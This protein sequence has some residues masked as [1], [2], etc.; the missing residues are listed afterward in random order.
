MDGGKKVWVP[1]TADGFKLGRITDIG[2]DNISIEPFDAPGTTIHSV[3]DRV[4]PAEEY[5]NK[6]VADN[7]GLMYLNEATLLHNLRIRYMKNMIYTYTANILIALNPYYEVPDLYTNATIQK[8]QGKSLGTMPPHVYAIADKALRDMKVTK[9]SQSIIVSG[10]SGAGKTESTKYI[11]KYLTMSRGQSSG[12]IEQRILESNPLL[13]A[14]GNAKTMRNN[15]SSRFG[16]F[17][18]IH[19]S[20]KMMLAGGFISHYLL[21]KSRICVQSS[22]ERNYHIFYRLCAGAPDDLYQKLKLAPP[23]HFRYLNRGCTQYFCG[24]QSDKAMSQG[25]KSKQY[26][27]DGSLSDPVIDDVQNFKI[28]DDA[29]KH[30]G[31]SDVDRLSVYKLVAGVLH[32]GNIGFEENHEDT[33]GGCKVVGGSEVALGAAAEL[34]ALDKEELREALMSRIMQAA[35]GGSK[36]TIIKVPLK[37]GEASNARDALAKSIYSRLFD[38]IVSSI[39]KSIPFSSSVSFIGLL[40][41]AGFEYFQVNSFEQFC[42]NY[43]NEKLQQFFND[44]IL[45]EEQVLYEK[46]GLNVK[47]IEWTDNKDCIDLIEMKGC[48][49]FD[50]LDEESKLPQPKPDHFTMEVHNRNKKHFRLSLPRK[51]KLKMHRDVRDEEGF[52]IRHFA[53]AVCYHTVQFIE[54]NNDA[55]HA[56]LEFLIQ[57]SKNELLKK[58]FEGVKVSSGKLNFIS[59]GS[60]FRSQLVILMEKLK[61]TGTNFIRCIKPNLKM[62]DHMF[63]GAQILS[64]LECSGMNSVLDLMQQGFPSRTQFSELYN[65]Y[66]RYLPPELARL[67]PRLFCKAL[68]KALGL[69]DKDFKFGLTKV[70][71]R[72]GK[73]AEFDQL[74]KSDPENLA[75]LV[76]KVKRWLIC[77]RWKKA[78]WCALSAIK[79]KNKILWRREQIVRLQKTVRMW[80]DVRKFKPKYKMITK[81]VASQGQMTEMSKIVSQLKKDKDAATKQVESIQTA[82]HSFIAK[83]RK[84]DISPVEMEKTYNNLLTQMDQNTQGIRKL[85]E[86]QKIKEEE[87]RLRKIQEEM[88][89]EKKRKEEEERKKREEEAERKLKVEMEAKRKREE[90]EQKKKAEADRLE[91]EKMKT[92]LAKEANE[93]KERQ[94]QLEQEHRDRELALRLAMEDQNAVEDVV[95]PPLQSTTKERSAEVQAARTALLSKKYDL[96]KWKYAD[97]RDT[98]NTSCDIELLDACRAEFHRRLKVY[99]A[100]KSRNKKTNDN[101]PDERAPKDLVENAEAM[102]AAT[103]QSI[104]QKPNINTKQDAVQRFFRIPFARP[105]DDF[106]DN[107]TGKKHGMWWAHFDGQWIARQMEMYPEKQPIIL[108][109]GVDDMQMCELS[110]EETGLGR[111]KGAEIL[112]K[113]FEAEW[114]KNGGKEYLKKHAQKL[115]SQFLRKRQGL[116]N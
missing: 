77:S 24:R 12:Q 80:R 58:M 76:K 93:N 5:D 53:G 10:E 41:I 55:M 18:E 4:F 20:G 35:K 43:C 14:F 95:V 70:F 101:T 21:E 33:K 62:V 73:F 69:D 15:N 75:T 47:K 83:I 32:L 23:D 111:K 25:R 27:K 78:Q 91:R 37:V 105:S 40:D 115:S 8:Y 34:L 89:R 88:E 48:G 9:L 50:L 84:T 65:M 96:S 102:A 19:F 38:F 90:E 109:S 61:A 6:D 98:I 51:S 74:M 92:L 57:D 13:E 87:D 99:H 26:L 28:C 16:K 86:K 108:V 45:K 94:Q 64:Q 39:N 3:Y 68:F 81:V 7:C 71:F 116:S 67:D 22:N 56:S 52:L 72:P 66:K 104:N 100:W 2:S 59:I 106:R 110:L 114:I 54:K 112:G 103:G 11:L 113:D 49:I 29:M 30:L 60:K 97:L 63:E 31:F 46:E 1:H 107:P 44:R 36:G 82:F 42:I 79:L 85:L 17:I